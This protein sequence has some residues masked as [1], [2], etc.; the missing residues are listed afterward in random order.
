M[1]GVDALDPKGSLRLLMMSGTDLDAMTN[2]VS[3]L[4]KENA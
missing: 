3:T 1:N 4:L 2:D